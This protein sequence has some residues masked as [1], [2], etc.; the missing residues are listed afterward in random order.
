M[1]FFLF[2]IF[3]YSVSSY[4]KNPKNI[5]LF[6]GDGMGM[7]HIALTEKFVEDYIDK[8]G[9]VFTKF[10]VV[11]LSKTY[12]Y[13]KFITDSA[14]AGTAI[15][16]GVKT[17]FNSIAI[18]PSGENLISVA[19]IAKNKAK[20]VAIISKTNL[21]DATPSVFYAN[22][23][24][25][26][27]LLSIAKQ[28][29]SSSFD[30]IAG[31]GFLDDYDNL[32]LSS[33]LEN[34]YKYT[35]TKEDF[36]KLTSSDKKIYARCPRLEDQSA[37]MFSIDYKEEDISLSE[38]TKKGIE[39]L[40]NKNGFFMMV[41]AGVL[42]WAAHANDAYTIINEIIEFDNAIKIAL[43][44]YKKNIN[45]TL[46]LVISDHET[47][48]LGLGFKDT[49]YEIYLDKLKGQNISREEFIKVLQKLYKDKNLKLKDIMILI[50]QYFGISE[51]SLSKKDL[52]DLN[53]ALRQSIVDSKKTK[54]NKY[55]EDVFAAKFIEIF[56]NK[57]GIS[58]TTTSHTAVPTPI[59]AIGVGSS[60]FDSYVDNTDIGKI[61]IKFVKG[62]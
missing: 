7:S 61:L 56:N 14:A 47:G 9:L 1:K 31:G 48:G 13:N 40:D 57:A 25:R 15:A 8:N 45:N 24:K 37:C 12:A 43:D 5:F 29:S 54:K 60:K 51:E 3:I 58:W 11:G 30:F 21:N 34:N 55:N 49:K 23:N 53:N 41:E 6:I 17:N 44:F 4:S 33:L 42:D 20:K 38:F 18:S 62:K 22:Q 27:E 26:H 39:L 35:Y 50:E 19:K 52:K 28:I 36:N 10:P 46:I 2:F 32:A 16:T 59:F